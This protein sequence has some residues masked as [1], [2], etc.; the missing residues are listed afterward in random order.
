MGIS[1]YHE[2]LVESLRPGLVKTGV[3]ETETKKILESIIRETYDAHK[4]R[5]E[6]GTRIDN[7]HE[8]LQKLCEVTATPPTS[9]GIPAS[10]LK[11]PRGSAS[12]REPDPVEV[13]SEEKLK[14]DKAKLPA[15]YNAIKA[16]QTRLVVHYKKNPITLDNYADLQLFHYDGVLYINT[17]TTTFTLPETGDQV[18]NGEMMINEGRMLD[19]KGGLAW[20]IIG[21]NG[22]HD[23]SFCVPDTGGGKYFVRTLYAE[24]GLKIKTYCGMKGASNANAPV[25]FYVV[26]GGELIAITKDDYQAL[27]RLRNKPAGF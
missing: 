13:S 27:P 4:R 11:K 9:V 1:K 10:A 19:P 6:M 26:R 17:C 16:E 18:Y 21:E 7:G 23:G 25:R 5:L 14:L 24:E 12:V 2:C 15:H 8:A 22:M 3:S 20:G